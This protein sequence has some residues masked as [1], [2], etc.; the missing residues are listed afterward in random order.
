MK[1]ILCLVLTL[2]LI[3]SSFAFQTVFADND[4]IKI[5]INGEEKTFDQMPV[6]IS[7][8]V[9]VP[10]RAIFETLGA[11]VSWNNETNTATGV[12]N[13]KQVKITIGDQ[14]AKVNGKAVSLDV[15]AMLINDRTMVPVRFIAESLG[16]DVKWIDSENKV[17]ITLTEK[18]P[19]DYNDGRVIEPK[20]NLSK[21]EYENVNDI[22]DIEGASE[23]RPIPTKFDHSSSYDDL[24]FYPNPKDPDEVFKSLSGGEVI[25]TTETF[26]SAKVTGAKPEYVTFETASAENMPFTDVIRA[27]TLNVP[28]HA[29]ECA[30]EIRPQ[31]NFKKGDVGMILV[32]ARLLSGGNGDTNE[33]KLQFT[34]QEVESGEFRSALSKEVSFGS[35]WKKLYIPFVVPGG[36]DTKP[37]RF[38][39]R[40][41]F[42]KQVVEI[43]G[44]ELI[45]FGDK[46][47]LED[48]PTSDSYRGMEQD[49][50]W[51]K[52]ALAR[53]DEIRKGDICVKVVDKDGNAVSDADVK[54]NMY[55]SEFAWGA[56]IGTEILENT[57]KSQKY[58][59]NLVKYFNG[60]V[61]ETIQKWNYYEN[62]PDAANGIVDWGKRNGIKN[63]RFHTIVWDRAYEPG[64]S[65]TPP[66]LGEFVK[67]GDKEKAYARIKKHIEEVCTNFKGKITEYDVINELTRNDIIL[68]PAFGDEI[69]TNVFKWAKEADPNATMAICNG[70]LANETSVHY[71]QFCAFL[72][73][74]VANGAPFDKIAV[75]GHQGNP[76]DPEPFYKML[77]AF[78]EKYHKP[79]VIS[80]YDIANVDDS[81][82]ANFF[83]DSLISIYSNKN[84]DGFYIWGYYDGGSS[85]RLITD[86]DFNL[87]KSGKVFE[88]MVYNKWWTRESGKTLS[89]GTFKTR[90]FFG[91]Y[92][93]TVTKDGKTKN[94]SNA[95]YKDS[96]KTLVI[97]L[98]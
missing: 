84:V 11:K 91:D 62:Y 56:A 35:E 94:V 98:D 8:R 50:A 12:R 75:Q 66:D 68:T 22:P 32:Y 74:M 67:N 2:L 14:T 43:G 49:A 37:L 46:Y 28:D 26:K 10:L 85:G 93:I 96:E 72:D 58:R 92:D 51:R 36:V 82:Q 86:K 55:E 97:T 33:G 48:M 53:I 29:Y 87:R 7:N 78:G 19:V 41:G 6:M 15:G 52:E 88:D 27:E 21:L 5:V 64:V 30:I 65:A 59:E 69:L 24:I 45:N 79:I 83:R 20:E 95:F 16:A 76:T 47:K 40:P 4:N 25:A 63:F 70:G 61:A 34:V 18:N 42:Y 90:G 71:K 81:F 23:R 57:G 31:T 80:E 44:Y 54:L 39:I 13:D 1:K 73:K 3:V 89:D 77:D 60:I 9:L 17:D 38:H